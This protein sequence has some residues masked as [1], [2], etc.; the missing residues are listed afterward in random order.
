MKSPFPGMDPFL[1]ARWGDVHT[2]LTTYACD[3]LQ[4]QLPPDLR[5]RI[6]NHLIE[7]YGQDLQT[8]FVDDPALI[9]GMRVKIGCDVYDGSVRGALDTLQAAF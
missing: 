4:T 5:A 6:E 3:Q 8:S 7:M 9:G 2:R 1:E